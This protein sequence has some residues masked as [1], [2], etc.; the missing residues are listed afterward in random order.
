MLILSRINALVLE[1]YRI[2]NND[3]VIDYFRTWGPPFLEGKTRESAYF[4]SVNRNKKSVCVDIS[5]K[6]GQDII[7]K[8]GMF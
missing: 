8:L 4:V 3:V 5:Q 1:Y 6:D 7:A 2:Y